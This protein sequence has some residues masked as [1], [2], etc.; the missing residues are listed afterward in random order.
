MRSFSVLIASLTVLYNYEAHAI[1]VNALKRRVSFASS[2]FV[3]VSLSFENI[4]FATPLGE[5]S[6]CAYPAC[7]TQL[8]VILILL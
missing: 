3:A 5:H 1:F 4:A 6:T 7:T 2:I 8:E